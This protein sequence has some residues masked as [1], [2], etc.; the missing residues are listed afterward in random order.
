MNLA[1]SYTGGTTV[2]FGT[3]SIGNA[4]GSATGTGPVAIAAGATLSGNGFISTTGGNVV[5]VSGSITPDASPNINS[6]NTLTANALNLNSGSSLNLNFNTPLPGQHD[7]INVTSA[8]TLASGIIN[9]DA[10]NLSG[11]WSPGAYTFANYGSLINGSPTFNIVNAAG[12]LG[13]SQMSIDESVPGVIS[14]DVLSAGASTTL[15]WVGNQNGGLWDIGNT[16]NWSNSGSASVYNE[17]NKVIFSN[18][19]SNFTV[20]VNQPVNPSGTTFSNNSLNN[21]MLNGSSGIASST[22]GGRR[23]TAAEPSLSTIPIFTPPP[24]QSQ[25]A[26]R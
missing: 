6:F 2:S 20:T 16:V 10:A 9:I 24:P 11:T 14:L 18:T 23:S 25:T 26:A 19:A 17:G 5:S 12:A 13:S 21:Y 22:L 3:L 1:N 8:L 4:N 15:S 7:L